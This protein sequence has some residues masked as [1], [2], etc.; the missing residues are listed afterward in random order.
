MKQS[1]KRRF[2]LYYRSK[3]NLGHGVTE[4]KTYPLLVLSN[5]IFVSIG[6]L[7]HLVNI[8]K[9]FSMDLLE[10][11][12]EMKVVLGLNFTLNQGNIMSM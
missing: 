4:A 5:K 3:L 8:K 6:N 1:F 11:L 12:L 10:A 7:I 9:L 2:R